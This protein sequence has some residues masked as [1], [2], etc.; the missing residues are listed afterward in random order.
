LERLCERGILALPAGPRVL[1]LLPPLVISREQLA[2]VLQVVEDVLNGSHSAECQVTVEE[3]SE[4]AASHSVCVQVD[5]RA[6]NTVQ[7]QSDASQMVST[8]NEVQLEGV[9]SHFAD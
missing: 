7:Q 3:Q 4:E 9:I 8:Y 5:T 1:R 2:H 6:Y